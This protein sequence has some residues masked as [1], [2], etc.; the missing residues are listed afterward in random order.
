MNKLQLALMLSFLC[1]CFWLTT[2]P[3]QAQ[4]K[5]LLWQI[6][7]KKITQ[8]T[9]LYGTIH[10]FD[11]SLYRLPQPVM[12]KLAQTKQV[13]FELDFSKL[14][15]IELMGY[16]FVKDTAQRLDKLLDS[17]SLRKLQILMKNV[18]MLQMLGD[19]IY[20]FKPLFLSTMLM[21]NGKAV[22]IDMEMF[23]RAQELKD[24]VGGLETVAEQ[25]QA[26]DLI[27]VTTQAKM[28]QDML[29]TYTSADDAIK[30]LTEIYVKQNVDNLLEEMNDNTPM[31]AAF[32]E[33]LLIKRNAVMA[34]RI[35]GLTGKQST[36][37]AVGAGHLGG[38]K[39]LI[40]LLKQK[41]YT[42]KAVPFVFTKAK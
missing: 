33:A 32:N 19:N 31:D 42:L 27:P 21:N 29:K 12:A 37:I 41:G 3:A 30:K 16:A 13:Y 14:N 28:M 25:M 5:G 22:T 10:L 11:T 26:L 23:K 40:A 4:T 9:Y 17:A 7:G 39:G 15:P 24:S 38:P 2:M 18:P 20:R 1:A 34:N 36:M 8:P 35:D 6:T